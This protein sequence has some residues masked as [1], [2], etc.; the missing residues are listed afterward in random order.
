MWMMYNIPG[1]TKDQAYDAVRREFYALRQ[2]EEVER[3]IAREEAMMV[4][5]YFGKSFLQVGMQLEDEQ[6]EKWR[7]W[8][9]KQIDAVR[10]EQSQAYTSFGTDDAD[11]DSVDVEDELAE[12]AAETV[13][14]QS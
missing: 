14:I 11:P 7:K 1:M 9:G 5:A 10:S 8:A 12:E 4:G 2:Q 3:R 6:F 13:P